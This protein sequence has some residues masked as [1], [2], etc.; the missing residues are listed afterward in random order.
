MSQRELE[1][2]HVPTNNDNGIWVNN[3]YTYAEL[4][5]PC[6]FYYYF[7]F[8]LATVFNRDL[9]TCRRRLGPLYYYA[10]QAAK[11]SRHVLL[12]NSMLNSDANPFQ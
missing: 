8:V 11:V 12:L 1:S 2:E 3:L 7:S 9:I 5:P 6:S 4:T 10:R